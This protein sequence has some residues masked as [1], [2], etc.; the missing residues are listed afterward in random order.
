MSASGYEGGTKSYAVSGDGE[1]TEV[2]L[3]PIAATSSD[4]DM[5]AVTLT[6]RNG[7]GKRMKRVQVSAKLKQK[8]SATSDSVLLGQPRSKTTNDNGRVVFDM[9]Q[10]AELQYGD[11]EYELTVHAPGFDGAIDY[12]APNSPSASFTLTP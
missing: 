11:G 10:P 6:V 7:Q 2:R 12:T 9:V 4:P 5:C 8:F 3:T 1:S